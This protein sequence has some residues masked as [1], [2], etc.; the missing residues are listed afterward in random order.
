MSFI[1]RDLK[2]DN[3]MLGRKQKVKLSLNIIF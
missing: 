2:P 3:F 1:H